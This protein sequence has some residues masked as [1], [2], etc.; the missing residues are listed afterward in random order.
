MVARLPWSASSRKELVRAPARTVGSRASVA[1]YTLGATLTFIA[2]VPNSSVLSVSLAEAL[3]GLTLTSRRVQHPP[4][5]LSSSILV[6]RASRYGTCACFFASAC[7]TCPKASSEVLILVA[8]C[9][10]TPSAWDFFTRSLPAKSTT[11][12]LPLKTCTLSASAPG[13]ETPSTRGYLLMRSWRMEWERDECL[14]MLVSAYAMFLRPLA[15]HCMRKS[16]FLHWYQERSCTAHPP[17]SGSGVSLRLTPA[18]LRRSS[19]VS[20]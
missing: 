9:S 19:I 1:T 20:L 4:D 3:E 14:F 7:T 11:V 17:S 2:R 18:G 16:A 8:S 6:R 10:R 5:M 15:T 13:E 12:S